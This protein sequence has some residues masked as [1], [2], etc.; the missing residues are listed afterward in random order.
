MH[1][2]IAHGDVCMFDKE[3][4]AQSRSVEGG[5]ETMTVYVTF[6][7]DP[8]FVGTDEEHLENLVNRL[9]K[10]H[11]EDPMPTCKVPATGLIH[12]SLDGHKQTVPFMR[13]RKNK[14][15]WKADF[16]CN[17]AKIRAFHEQ[18]DTTSIPNWVDG[19]L[20]FTPCMKKRWLESDDCY[21]ALH[22]WSKCQGRRKRK[23]TLETDREEAMNAIGHSWGRAQCWDSKFEE[24]KK[25]K[26]K[27][28]HCNVPMT[29]KEH[30][31]LA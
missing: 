24:L 22:S 25:H 29:D 12:A 26:E 11:H 7:P 27:V 8:E 15:Q 14:E 10:G 19:E 28:G 31:A 23:D 13:P 9:K 16:D 18:F 21:A 20:S 4:R 30:K 6:N 1:I 2:P 5:N 17:H 3:V